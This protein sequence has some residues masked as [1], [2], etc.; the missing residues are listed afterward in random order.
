[1]TLQDRPNGDGEDGDRR[2]KDDHE[3]LCIS[4]LHLTESGTAL[5]HPKARFLSH[6]PT[7]LCYIHAA[8]S[9]TAVKEWS[10]KSRP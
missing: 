3:P 10:T 4:M 1:M 2:M 8:S 5:G 7:L 9:L 6:G